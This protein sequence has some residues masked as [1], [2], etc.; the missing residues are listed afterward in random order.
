MK[1]RTFLNA[2]VIFLY[3]GCSQ[4][5]GGKNRTEEGDYSN[6]PSTLS[7]GYGRM[8]SDNP[9]I[10]SGGNLD[11]NLNLGSLLTSEQTFFTNENSLKGTCREGINPC[12]SVKQNSSADYLALNQGTWGYPVS[13]DQFWEGHTFGHVKTMIEKMEDIFDYILYMSGKYRSSAHYLSS[14]PSTLFSSLAHFY[15]GQELKSFSHC[16]L[17]D[18]ASFS[19]TN[20]SLCFGKISKYSHHLPAWSYHRV[21]PKLL[22]VPK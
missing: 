9:Y 13:S 20:F 2:F 16:N 4:S 19:P 17:N 11:P 3:V 7:A 8:L 21:P 6:S 5:S 1:T 14:I 12:Y 22:K 18:N 15:G 10:L